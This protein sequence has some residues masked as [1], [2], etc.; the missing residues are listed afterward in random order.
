VPNKHIPICPPGPTPEAPDIPPQAEAQSSLLHPPNNFARLES[1]NIT[2]FKI[3][4]AGV[5]AAL[6]HISRQPL[7]EPSQVF[8]WFH[9][10]HPNNH[11]QHAFF[12]QRRRA[13]RRTP[14][15]LRSITVVKAD[16]DLSISRLKGAIAPHE[17][18]NETDA[19]FLEVDPREGFSVRNFQIQAAK[20]AM[21]SDIIVYGD[22]EAQ[23]RTLGWKISIAQSNWRKAHHDD[24]PVYNTFICTSPFGEFETLFDDIVAVDSTGQVTGKVVDFFHQERREMYAM[25]QASEISHNVWMGPTPEVADE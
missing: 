6:D 13:L 7:P 18:L 9:G 15:C 14:E 8:P 23:V 21:T 2:I 22:D 1:G 24:L 16:G 5:A 4:A 25:T 3:D 19:E 10:L 12:I 11:I 20:T 17:F